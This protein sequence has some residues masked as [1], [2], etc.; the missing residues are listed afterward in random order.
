MENACD[1]RMK[2][3]RA[4]GGSLQTGIKYGILKREGRKENWVGTASDY[5][6]FLGGRVLAKLMDSLQATPGHRGVPDQAKMTWLCSLPLL[7]H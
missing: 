1:G 2:E 7:S 5:T 4:E 3:E 6:A